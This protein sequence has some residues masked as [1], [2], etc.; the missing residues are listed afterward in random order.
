MFP[1]L[2][3]LAGELLDFPS[4]AASKRFSEGYCLN[5]FQTCK[6]QGLE[7]VKMLFQYY[8]LLDRYDP[9][10]PDLLDQGNWHLEIILRRQA[11]WIMRMDY[12]YGNAVLKILVGDA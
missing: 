12:Q 3:R 6:R 2:E 4:F 7:F 11:K 9:V 5:L 1:N 10:R 8:Q